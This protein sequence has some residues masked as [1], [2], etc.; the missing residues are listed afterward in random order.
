MRKVEWLDFELPVVPGFRGRR[1]ACDLI[2][3][4]HDGDTTICE[5]KYS[6]PRKA[7]GA[8]DPDYAIFELLFQLQAVALNAH[9]FAGICH[10][11]ESFRKFLWP[12]IASAKTALIVAITGW[13]SGKRPADQKRILQLV[14]DIRTE[15]GVEVFLFQTQDVEFAPPLRPYEPKWPK[16]VSTP[17]KTLNWPGFQDL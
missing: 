2:A 12:D 16:G 9:L 17:W 15:V 3:K 7:S 1:G 10:R 5:A 6:R 14:D 8:R 4:I 13:W 11:G